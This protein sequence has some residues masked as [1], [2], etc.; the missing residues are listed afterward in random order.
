MNNLEAHQE[1]NEKLIVALQI[2][3]L[4]KICLRLFIAQIR[5]FFAKDIKTGDRLFAFRQAFTFDILK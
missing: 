5:R 1:E 3:I 4:M 2:A